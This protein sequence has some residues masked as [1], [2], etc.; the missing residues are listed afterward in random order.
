VI[1]RQVDVMTRLVDDLLDVSRITRGKVE[2]RRERVSLQTVV[3]ET[4]EASQP[5]VDTAGHTLVVDVPGDPI[6]L[7]ADP[8]R[9]AQALFNLLSNA[10][11]YTPDGGTIWLTARTEENHVVISVKDTGI[12]MKPDM[13][14]AV[15]DMFMQGSTSIEQRQ[16][17]IGI[18]LTLVR[19]LVELHGG[20]IEA[21]SAGPG[22]GSE[23]IVRLPRL[24]AQAVPDWAPSEPAAGNG[25]KP[26]AHRILVVDDNRD[27]AESMA[28]YLRHEGH[29]VRTAHDGRTALVAAAEFDPAV[30]LL[31][32]GLPEINGYDVAR[33]LRKRNGNH[34]GLVAMTGWGGEEDKRRAK[35]SG[36]DRH[37][38]KPVN[39]DQLNQAI[40]DASRKK[41]KEGA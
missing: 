19:R 38:T 29:E 12:G 6:L 32:I 14:P 1:D 39:F 3:R 15:F 23:F 2:L 18:G 22:Q 8:T 33:E 7:D 20:E 26:R 4:V 40:D 25:T 36:F 10:A 41:E 34:V 27:S 13:L 17:G 35:E 28:M 11:K 30:I 9:L 21:N 16:G 37:L 5:L 31:D 24:E